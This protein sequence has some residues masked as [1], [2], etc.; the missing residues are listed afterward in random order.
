MSD[1]DEEIA[2]IVPTVIDSYFVVDYYD[3]PLTGWLRA[4]GCYWYFRLRNDHYEV[5]AAPREERIPHLLDH[6][7]FRSMVGRH[8]DFYPGRDRVPFD[9]RVKPEWEKFYEDRPERLPEPTVLVRV[10]RTKLYD[11]KIVVDVEE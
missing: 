11:W 7:K 10:G 8:W 1:V 5:F 6:R 9:P 2:A 3:Q 4:G